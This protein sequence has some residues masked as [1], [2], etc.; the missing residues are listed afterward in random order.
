NKNN[1]LK[2][3]LLAIINAT[4]FSAADAAVIPANLVQTLGNDKFVMTA[5]KE[6]DKWLAK[7]V[8]VNTGLT[9]KGRIHVTSG[10]KG[11]EYIITEGYL[12]VE[13]GDMLAPLNK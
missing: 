6:G 13:D 9:Q 4:D 2:P 5:K 8:S 12:N 1:K 7:R 10:L 11:D 3:N